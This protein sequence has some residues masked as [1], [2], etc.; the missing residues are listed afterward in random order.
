M[1]QI[2]GF[3]QVLNQIIN[4]RNISKEALVSALEAAL[5]S[6]A[7]K[8]YHLE[9]E[10]VR[11]KIEEDGSYKIF[12]LKKVVGDATNPYA[13]ISFKEAKKIQPDIALDSTL[14]I[15]ITGKDFG[16]IAAQTAK[17]VIIQRIRE[18]EKNKTLEEFS[19][20]KGELVSGTIQRKEFNGFLV[21]LGRLESILTV[22]EQARGEYYRIGEK[23][24]VYVVDVQN[25]SRG[26]VVYISRAHPGIIKK[27]F[28]MEIP[29]IQQGVLEI[30][31]IAR[32]A[33]RRSKVA[34]LSHDPNVTAIGTCVGH[35]GNRIQNI[36][37]EIGN[38]RID[39]IEWKEDPKA[40]IVNALS[41]AK[42]SAVKLNP[43][44]NSAKIIV[45]EDQLSLAIGKEGQNV[46]LAAKL[47]GWK[48]DI[49]N[50]KNEIPGDSKEVKA[51][52]SKAE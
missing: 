51:D 31:G 19:A 25:S 15:E 8:K 9:N 40:F 33:G 21:N 48:I 29:E 37:R 2:E 39:I 16:R 10:Q 43:E 1:V 5:S 3:S 13:E 41:P 18:A 4:D 44:D 32:E 24:K 38:E 26:A 45:P 30:K 36:L 17:Q 22:S 14:E 49:I 23:I 7:K 12:A 6:A 47:T 34:V 27:L 46:R 20:K 50:E 52:E 35:M 11:A 28:E 42:I